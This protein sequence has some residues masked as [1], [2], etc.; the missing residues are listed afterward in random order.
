[1]G[2]KTPRPSPRSLRALDASNLA[3]ADVRN[4]LRPYLAFLAGAEECDRAAVERASAAM[5][6][7]EAPLTERLLS[8]LADRGARPGAVDSRI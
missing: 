5:A 7:L 4:G 6:A 1:M 8:W 2:E 3:L